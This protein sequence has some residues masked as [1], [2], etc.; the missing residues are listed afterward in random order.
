MI[1]F[2][3]TLT[4]SPVR[5]S[6][7]PVSFA[8]AVER[9]PKRVDLAKSHFEKRRVVIAR[10]KA[11]IDRHLDFAKHETLRKLEES[12]ATRTLGVNVATNADPGGVGIDIMFDKERFEQGILAALRNES[13]GAVQEAAEQLL[14]EVGFTDPW[15]VPDPMVT[16]F[17]ETRQNLLS[18]VPD[19]IF[20]TIEKEI[21]EGVEAGD[22]MKELAKRIT[23]AFDGISTGRANTIASTE[24]G[25]AY[26]FG[27]EHAMEKA[28]V[29][30]KSWLTSHLP[31]VR[32]AH[33]IA[34]AENQRI[35][36][37]QPFLVDGEELMYPGDENGSPENTINCHCVALA[38]P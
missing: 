10:F 21:R 18:G 20:N 36:F 22:S 13:G 37:D 30:H 4:Q 3:Q 17:I 27:R 16:G 35:P 8:K 38:V 15:S 34:E 7:A 5:F 26:G 2:S 31:N 9:D 6:A 19:E 12:R 28:G 25:A 23:D 29:T 32:F 14:E 1:R 11:A 33:M 24:T